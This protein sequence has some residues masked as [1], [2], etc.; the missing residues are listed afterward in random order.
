MA[1]RWQGASWTPEN[2]A[3]QLGDGLWCRACKTRHGYMTLGISYDSPTTSGVNMNWICKR[4]GNVVG[5]KVM[6]WSSD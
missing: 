4:T 6:G 1:R 5:T 3:A 2:V